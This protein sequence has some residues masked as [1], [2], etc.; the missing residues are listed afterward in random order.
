MTM[1]IDAEPSGRGEGRRAH[2]IVGED[3]SLRVSGGAAG[4]YHECIAG[5]DTPSFARGAFAFAR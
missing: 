4:G 3:N 5:L 2:C 1:G